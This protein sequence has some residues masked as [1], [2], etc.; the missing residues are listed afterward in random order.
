MRGLSLKKTLRRR[1]AARVF[2]VEPTTIPNAA[3]CVRCTVGPG[4]A[5]GGVDQRRSI[6]YAHDATR[7]QRGAVHQ[8]AKRAYTA[9]SRCAAALRAGL[10]LEAPSQ[11]PKRLGPRREELSEEEVNFT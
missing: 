3:M 7:T 4:G 8:L 11:P 6:S 10:Q 5:P 1:A 9:V 2:C